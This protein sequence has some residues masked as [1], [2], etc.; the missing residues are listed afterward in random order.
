MKALISILLL[1][2]FLPLGRAQTIN[3]NVQKNPANGELT[4]NFTNPI[5]GVITNNGT[6]SGPGNLSTTGTS[7]IGMGG[8]GFTLVI[9]GT[10]TLSS[11]TA[12]VTVTGALPTSRVF[13]SRKQLNVTSAI[14]AA[15]IVTTTTGSFTINATTTGNVTASDN[16]TF[17]WRVDN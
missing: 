1:F 8:T 3:T 14:S 13:L 9:E 2:T 16:S 4:G 12:N 17:S 10:A 11:G 6:I 15:Q 7:I 5:G